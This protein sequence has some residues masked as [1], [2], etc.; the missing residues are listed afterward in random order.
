M[1]GQGMVREWLGLVTLFLYSGDYGLVEAGRQW[2]QR[3]FD[4][5][6]FTKGQDRNGI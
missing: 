6:K 1:V 2:N 4:V 3:L 5:H